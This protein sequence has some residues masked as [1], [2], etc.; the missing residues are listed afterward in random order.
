[1]SKGLIDHVELE[2]KVPESQ[3]FVTPGRGNFK[4]SEIHQSVTNARVIL[5]PEVCRGLF[6][7]RVR[8]RNF[9]GS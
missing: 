8:R 6:F 1:M 2:G 3:E 9:R 4:D 5:L 7:S